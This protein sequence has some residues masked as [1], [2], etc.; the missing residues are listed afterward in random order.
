MMPRANGGFTLIELLVVVVIIG[1]LAAIALPNFVNAQ[2][3][4]KIAG[5]RS[6]MHTCQLCA[7]CYAVDTGG[8]YPDNGNQ[9]NPYYPGGSSTI[10]G[11][12]GTRPT[13]PITNAANDGLAVASVTLNGTSINRTVAPAA[14]GPGRTAYAMLFTNTSYAVVGFNEQGTPLRGATPST[15]AILS[16]Q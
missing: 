6:N 9:L 10:G 13:N 16:N 1:I 4:S 5:V 3:K 8:I 7:E 12:S 11:T 2:M 14:G 15:Y